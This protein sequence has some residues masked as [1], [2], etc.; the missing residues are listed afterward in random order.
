MF[1]ILCT[2]KALCCF[3]KIPGFFCDLFFVV[4]PLD[5][6]SW[7]K[8]RIDTVGGSRNS[9]TQPGPQ[10][11]FLQIF[12]RLVLIH[13]V[14]SCYIYLNSYMISS[15]P[16]ITCVISSNGMC[17]PT[18]ISCLMGFEEWGKTSDETFLSVVLFICLISL[19]KI[20]KVSKPRN[21]F[22][23]STP[24]GLCNMFSGCFF[25]KT[26]N[27][28]SH[29]YPSDIWRRCPSPQSW[30][31]RRRWVQESRNP[32]RK[33]WWRTCPTITSSWNPKMLEHFGYPKLVSQHRS[34]DVLASQKTLLG[35][36]VFL[37]P[38]GRKNTNN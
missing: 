2:E 14:L 29:P 30:H 13:K 26:L 23:T 4:I 10:R 1:N 31:S 38:N 24:K 37:S 32:K 21:I 9:G 22:T 11:F 5:R 34:C 19:V 27:L 8:H 15:I 18:S 7:R 28:R 16:M 35:L 20:L 25:W 36:F 3:R 6:N 33:H 17:L 12:H